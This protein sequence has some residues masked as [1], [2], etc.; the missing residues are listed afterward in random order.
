MEPMEPQR[1]IDPEDPNRDRSRETGH[2]CCSY[3]RWKGMFIDV[4]PDCSI[5]NTRDGLFW[6]SLSMNCLGPDSHVADEQSCCS[7]RVCFEPW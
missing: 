6:C 1:T 4:E 2:G 3:L 7:G 5:P